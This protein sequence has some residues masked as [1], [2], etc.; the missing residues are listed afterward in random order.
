MLV[1]DILDLTRLQLSQLRIE[2]T[3]FTLHSVIENGLELISGI[4]SSKEI[5][6]EWVFDSPMPEVLNT[7]PV[8]LQ[9]ILT[10]LLSN[11][12]KFTERG[13]VI[14]NFS[15]KTQEDGEGEL[16]FKVKD[17]GVGIPPEKV[18][19]EKTPYDSYSLSSHTV[20]TI[21]QGHVQ[22]VFAVR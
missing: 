19:R 15:F 9:Q 16:E 6:V 21:D 3:N 4:A 12:L 5:E 17:T 11:A 18:R 2:S 7:D 10:N 22:T 13:S 14:I 8:R 1:N 20:P